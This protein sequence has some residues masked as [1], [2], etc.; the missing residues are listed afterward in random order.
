M[1]ADQLM[2]GFAPGEIAIGVPT[3][4]FPKP[5]SILAKR[6]A[7]EFSGNVTIF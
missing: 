1:Q 5:P 4:G 3:I 6:Y 7:S 2:N